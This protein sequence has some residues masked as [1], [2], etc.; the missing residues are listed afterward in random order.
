[1]GE[2]FCLEEPFPLSS[3]FHY[4]SGLCWRPLLTLTIQTIS[5]LLLHIQLNSHWIR[6]E[7]LDLCLCW[8]I[9]GGLK[10]KQPRRH[11]C[12]LPA[13]LQLRLKASTLRSH[14]RGYG[15]CCWAAVVT[16]SDPPAPDQISP[17]DWGLGVSASSLTLPSLRASPRARPTSAAGNGCTAYYSVISNKFT[18]N[19]TI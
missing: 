3:E 11:G 4:S 14:S 18:H 1:M 12:Q 6:G 10:A 16:C 2:T 7:M 9:S 8:K 5:K 17:H 19:F 13:Q 15:T